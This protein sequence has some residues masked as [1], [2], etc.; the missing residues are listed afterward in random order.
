MKRW[1]ILA[2]MLGLYR[3]FVGRIARSS[4]VTFSEVNPE[5][6]GIPS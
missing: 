3:L 2:A 4:Q 6:T 5:S 1:G